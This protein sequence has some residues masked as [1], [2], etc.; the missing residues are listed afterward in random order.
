MRFNV[1]IKQ[2]PIHL[3]R[4][5]PPNQ[6]NS[7]Y[8]RSLLVLLLCLLVNNIS[9]GQDFDGLNFGDSK[10][11]IIQVHPDVNIASISEEER[12]IDTISYRG[13]IEDK[14]VTVEFVLIHNQLVAGTYHFGNDS[15]EEFY[16]DFEEIYPIFRKMYGEPDNLHKNKKTNFK[17]AIWVI[18]DSPSYLIELDGGHGLVKVHFDW[19]ER[20]EK[21]KKEEKKGSSA[22]KKRK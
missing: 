5:K 13:T 6:T 19:S 9:Y 11:K 18:G 8:M 22:T 2:L 15:S 1:E 3:H 16:A 21:Y 12:D 7:K 4:Y 17:I 20:I 10:D 14:E